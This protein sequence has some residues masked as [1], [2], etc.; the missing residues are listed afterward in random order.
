MFH[1][2]RVAR[3]SSLE[4]LRSESKSQFTVHT[5]ENNITTPPMKHSGLTTGETPMGA[6]L[7]KSGPGEG[8]DGRGR[9]DLQGMRK[10][11]TQDSQ[12]LFAEKRHNIQQLE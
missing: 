6:L 2:G 1:V 12:V 3:H 5:T 9:W 7:Y 10:P 8:W 11:H 4:R